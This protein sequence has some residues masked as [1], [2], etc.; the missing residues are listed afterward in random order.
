MCTQT[1]NKQ[2]ASSVRHW[3]ATHQVLWRAAHWQLVA[4]HWHNAK[5]VKQAIHRLQGFKAE[6][7]VMALAAA[8]CGARAAVRWIDCW[9]VI[10]ATRHRAGNNM[11]LAVLYAQ[12]ESSKVCWRMWKAQTAMASSSWRLQVLSH[13]ALSLCSHCPTVL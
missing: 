3:R 7:E 13:C 12:L 8:D 2:L 1:A 10:A 5:A 6:L 4:S 9:R 11:D